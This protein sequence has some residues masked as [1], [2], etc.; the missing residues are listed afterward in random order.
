MITAA[1]PGEALIRRLRLR[2]ERLAL[3]RGEALVRNR[4]TAVTDWHSAASLWP[5]FGRD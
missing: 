2:A 1:V 4:R 5:D 3:A